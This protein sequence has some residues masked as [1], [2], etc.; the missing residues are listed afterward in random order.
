MKS[1]AK[2]T[3]ATRAHNVAFLQMCDHP[4]K[5]AP[6]HYYCGYWKCIRGMRTSVTNGIRICV[7]T[8]LREYLCIVQNQHASFQIPINRK[9]S[10][11]ICETSVRINECLV[12]I[13]ILILLLWTGIAEYFPINFMFLVDCDCIDSKRQVKKK[14]L[15][16]RRRAYARANMNGQVKISFTHN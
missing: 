16:K 4:Y 5:Q 15:G 7:H 11:H 3:S 13:L 2:H 14:R 12:L 10:I 8:S 1:D 6:Y 9:K